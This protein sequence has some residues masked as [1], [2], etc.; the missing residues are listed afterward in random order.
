MGK[1]RLDLYIS[2]CNGNVE[3]LCVMSQL[4]LV[5]SGEEKFKGGRRCSNTE[6]ALQYSY[7]TEQPAIKWQYDYQ[8]P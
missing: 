3:D 5:S 7:G 8:G 1:G 6:A 4:V 2:I